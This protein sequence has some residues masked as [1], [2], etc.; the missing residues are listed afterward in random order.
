MIGIDGHTSDDA[1]DCFCCHKSKCLPVNWCK[2]NRV[3]LKVPEDWEFTKFDYSTYLNSMNVIAAPDSLF[4]DQTINGFK[5]GMYVEAVDVVEPHLICPGI[6]MRLVFSLDLLNLG[7]FLLSSDR[8]LALSFK[9]VKQVAGQLVKISFVGWGE[10]FDQWLPYD[11]AEIY[12]IGWC[13]MV[14]SVLGSRIVLI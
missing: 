6:G 4:V 14:S 10:E 12:P 13:R 8:Y 9:I 3:S 2:R 11:S 7:I 1:S 5:K